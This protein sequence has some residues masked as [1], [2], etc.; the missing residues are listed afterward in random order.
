MKKQFRKFMAALVAMAMVFAPLSAVEVRGDT[1]NANLL[2]SGTWFE[3]AWALWQGS[4]AGGYSVYVQNTNGDA[5][6][7]RT[8]API[9][10]ASWLRDWTL[11]NDEANAPLLR[12]IDP[13]RN[14]WRVDI[15]GLPQGTY[16]IQVRDSGGSVLFS[17]DG[18]TTRAFPRYGAAFVPS[19]ELISN[20]AQNNWAP[21][22]ATGGYLPD[23]RVDP[24]AR[25][26]YVSHQNWADFTVEQLTRGSDFRGDNPAII[27]FLGTVGSFEAVSFDPAIARPLAPPSVDV[28]HGWPNRPANRMMTL[29]ADSHQITFEGIGPD[30][31][32]YGWGIFTGGASNVVVRNITIDQYQS[33]GIRASATTSNIWIHNNTLRY[34]QNLFLYTDDETD[35]AWA[36]GVI[37]IEQNVRGYTV[38]YNHFINVDKTHLVV[39]GVQNWTL[40][41]NGHRHYGTFHH[42]WYQETH[43]RN[44]RVRHHNVHT[45]NNLF[46]GIVGHPLHYRLMDRFSGYGIGAGHNATIWAEGNIFENTGFPFQRSRMGHARGYYPHTGHNHFFGDGP[47]FMVANRFVNHQ[48]VDFGVQMHMPAS[49]SEFGYWTGEIGTEGSAIPTPISEVIHL[50]S[51]AELARLTQVIRTL[52]PN[53]MDAV[54]WSEFDVS[55]DVGVLVNRDDVLIMPPA[56]D[57]LHGAAPASANL[58]AP[59]PDDAVVRTQGFPVL[60][61]QAYWHGWAFDGGFIPSALD[62]VWPTGTGAEIAALRA[63]IETYSGSM[64]HA[65]LNLPLVAPSSVSVSINDLEYMMHSRNSPMPSFRVITYA[66]TF[67]IGWASSDPLA[68]AYQIGFFDNGTWQVLDTILAGGRPNTFVTQDVHGLGYLLAE[69][70]GTPTIVYLLADGYSVAFPRAGF[71]SYTAAHVPPVRELRWGG[72]W[73]VAQ[74]SGGYQFGVRAIRD[75]QTSAWTTQTFNV[76]ANRAGI[77]GVWQSNA[78]Q[79]QTESVATFEVQTT[80]IPNG[81][82][83]IVLSVP[84]SMPR[85][86]M[87]WPSQQNFTHSVMLQGGNMSGIPTNAEAAAD[88]SLRRPEQIAG[89]GGRGRLVVENNIAMVAIELA[90][91]V[92]SGIHHLALTIVADGRNIT[93]PVAL[94]VGME[95]PAHTFAVVPVEETPI[96]DIRP[97]DRIPIR[98]VNGIPFVPFRITAYAHGAQPVEWDGDNRAVTTTNADGY[99]WTFVVADVGGFVE[100][101]RTYVPYEF[102]VSMFY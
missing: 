51:D 64:S 78:V 99:V 98:M 23:G 92:P 44:P 79:P 27:R 88:N 47:G 75:G 33:Y 12:R 3:T 85:D 36:R 58:A 48:G 67:T 13:S 55:I 8:G 42:N 76:A 96:Y 86:A 46:E 87:P 45:F 29:A 38:A 43:E 100:A 20:Q 7:W 35:R 65:S 69:Y 83:D 16:A 25:I 62:N 50:E 2:A 31:I 39:G 81:T 66:N 22:G 19:H 72:A 59:G 5:I 30:A 14:I 102:A 4:P 1:G 70:G 10:D 90:D 37:D 53:V 60:G 11:I 56:G 80:N 68:E 97:I 6:D 77:V 17:V 34:G 101:N 26:M 93:V 18:L 57:V 89:N 95:P 41:N 63:E 9:N 15:P 49:L 28:S 32:F 82:Y 24:D 74:G 71:G 61:Q 91:N 73:V 94:Y 52:Q 84:R 54:A 21:Y 40:D